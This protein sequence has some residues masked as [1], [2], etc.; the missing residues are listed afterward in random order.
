[1]VKTQHPGSREKC[2][3][4]GAFQ[5]FCHTIYFLAYG[6]VSLKTTV[7]LR[8]EYIFVATSLLCKVWYDQS[9]KI[10]FKYLLALVAGKISANI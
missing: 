9:V 3:R 1:M 2:W 4:V 10:R 8:W 5:K 7:R 6:N